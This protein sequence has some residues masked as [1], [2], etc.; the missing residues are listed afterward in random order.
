MEEQSIK[1]F[2]EKFV[3]LRHLFWQQYLHVCDKWVFIDGG[4]EKWGKQEGVCP[5]TCE[6]KLCGREDSEN[7]AVSGRVSPAH[8]Q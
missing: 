5:L 3:H 7:M 2:S 1:Y 4:G 8:R 6:R